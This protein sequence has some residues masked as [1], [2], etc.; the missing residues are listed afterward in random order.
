[1]AV[2]AGTTPIMI[3]LVVVVLA[4]FGLSMYL[5]NQMTSIKK[6]ASLVQIMSVCRNKPMGIIVDRSGTAIPFVSEPDERN[7][8]LIK[9]DY[10]IVN[11]DLIKSSTKRASRLKFRNGPETL[12]YPLPF[13][14]PMDIHDAAA[15]CQLAR[16]VRK[17]PDFSWIGNER[18]LLELIFNGTETF[19]ED[20]RMLVSTSISADNVVPEEFYID[21]EPEYEEDEEE[22]EEEEVE[23]EDEVEEEEEE[24]TDE[25][26]VF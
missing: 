9:N 23:E 8:G 17:H 21:P 15:L 12:I 16:K 7:K 6:F 14:F 4:L 22:E 24:E 2:L 11:P 20:C 10:T 25:R 3:I 5:L 1:M 26:Q 19:E 18:R 13:Y